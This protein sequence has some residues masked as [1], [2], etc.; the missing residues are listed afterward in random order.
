MSSY[1]QITKNAGGHVNMGSNQKSV[2]KNR[3]LVKKLKR[4]RKEPNEGK[5][6]AMLERMSSGFE[7][8]NPFAAGIDIASGEHWVCVPSTNENEC[9]RRFGAYTVHL[10]EIR[11]WLV[12][13][14]VTTVAMESTGVY[15]IPLYDLLEESGIEACLVNA[16]ELKSVCGR[17]KTDKL[18]CQ[19]I[20]RLHTYGLLK[21]SF[22]PDREICA[23]R[24]IWRNRASIV[25]EVN[26]TI[27]RMQKSLHEMNVLLTKVVTDV[28]G[29]TGMTIMRAIAAGETDPV[30][31]AGHRHPLVKKG[32]DE[33]VEALRGTY[34][35]EHVFLLKC[36]L[37]H[38]DFLL[39]QEMKLDEEIERRLVPMSTKCTLDG[40]TRAS[41]RKAAVAY[42]KNYKNAPC[43]DAQTRLHEML[44]VDVCQIPGI[45]ATNALGI[46]M[47]IGTDMTRW[48]DENHFSS[49]LSLSPNPNVSA[50][51]NLGTK[52]KKNSNSAAYQFRMAARTLRRND[53]PLGSFYRRMAARHGPPHAIT[54]TAHKLAVIFYHMVS[55]GEQYK[56]VDRSEY[57]R[58]IEERRVAN[59]QKRALKEGFELVPITA[60]AREHMESIA[61]RAT[62]TA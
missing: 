16:R 18:D 14:G 31:L 35:P 62:V 41:N 34:R 1:L 2:K 3:T 53:G 60:R 54:A 15:W 28:T 46:V 10:Y 48:P 27:Q 23:V 21:R 22:R 45:G 8:V 29:K 40:E 42:R 24:S 5:A 49:W 44:G 32:F 33:F 19:W 17:P 26:R 4:L 51:K 12:R 52:T 11:D 58:I 36:E 39:N 7:P 59:M 55:R 50:G 25:R 38:Y 37:E 57:E 6:L 47:E 43:F 13:H 61:N 9:I 30:K 20:Q 56:N